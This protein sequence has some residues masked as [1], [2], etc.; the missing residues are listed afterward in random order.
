MLN[1]FLKLGIKIKTSFSS[2]EFTLKYFKLKE[3]FKPLATLHFSSERKMMSI[4]VKRLSDGTYILFSKGSDSSMI[5]K[6]NHDEE[7]VSKLKREINVLEKKGLRMYLF[8]MKLL[9]NEL[10]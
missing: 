2:D 10:V 5:P 3:T 4:L 8:A 1:G 7:S 9:S 6:L